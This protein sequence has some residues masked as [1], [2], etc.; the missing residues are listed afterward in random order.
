[1]ATRTWSPEESIDLTFGEAFST[2]DL[3]PEQ[4][5]KV[6]Q[7]MIEEGQAKEDRRE[8]VRS[9]VERMRLG[10]EAETKHHEELRAVVGDD[11]YPKLKQILTNGSDLLTIHVTYDRQFRAAG[12]PLTTEQRLAL[13]QVLHERR[14]SRLDQSISLSMLDQ[15]VV[16]RA[17]A[18][19]D[20]T[21]LDVVE[22][23]LAKVR[24]GLAR[25]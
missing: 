16:S 10:A 9:A 7:L 23:Y 14:T 12:A 11:Q 18:F 8:V 6:K 2:L 21:Q 24:G 1:M 13:A 15:A 17:E 3:A 20:A 19:L 25:Q 22:R 4:L 5:A